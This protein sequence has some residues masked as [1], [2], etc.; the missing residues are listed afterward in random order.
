MTTETW[1]PFAFA[2]EGGGG[3]VTLQIYGSGD[4]M[5]CGLYKLEGR[6][7]LRPKAFIRT[8]RAELK[9]LEDIA[10]W[11]GCTEMRLAGRDWSKILPDYEPLPQLRNGL[12]KAL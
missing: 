1:G 8:V 2:C 4:H 11:S 10:R 3:E 5:V 9:K 6:I 12:R 7:D